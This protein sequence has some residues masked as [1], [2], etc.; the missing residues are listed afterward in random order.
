MAVAYEF[1]SE[2]KR[3]TWLIAVLF[4]LVFAALS[5]GCILLFLWV[6][7]LSD[8]PMET[9]SFPAV[10]N[11]TN[12]VATYF[13]PIVIGAAFIW[14]LFS[15]FNGDSM[16]LKNAHARE[17]SKRDNPELYRLVENLCIT[18]GLP[19]PRIYIM[20][21]SSLN[22][23]ATGRN[24][25][26]SSIAV[27]SGLLEKLTKPELEGVIAHELG[28]VGNRDITLMVIAIAGISFF[29]I[30]G[31]LLFRAAA[32]TGRSKDGGKA[33]LVIVLVAVLFLVFGYFIAPLLRLAMSRQREYLADATAALTTRN[34]GAIADAL[35]KISRDSR[36][37]VLDEH[38]SMAAMCIES[39]REVEASLFNKLAGL[40]ATHPPIAERIKRLREMDGRIDY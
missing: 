21:D 35:E 14:I 36:V 29:T 33:A 39:P 28:H 17:I 2:N 38:P 24:P 4:P 7:S 23:F 22:A 15:Y 31:E 5:Y 1:I 19:M 27:T 16:L 6:V 26:N 34:P 9:S 20:D 18:T 13:I 8:S 11:E 3:R 10:L 30:V 37:E 40:Y 12:T 32:R 25:Q